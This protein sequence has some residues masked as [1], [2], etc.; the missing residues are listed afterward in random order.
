MTNY[1]SDNE[2]PLEKPYEKPSEK[3]DPLDRIS[4]P[5]PLERISTNQDPL[6]RASRRKKDGSVVYIPLD[7]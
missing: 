6:D 1:N 7:D 3:K 5:S 4:G 2:K